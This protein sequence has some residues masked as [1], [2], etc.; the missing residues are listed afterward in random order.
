M[1]RPPLLAFGDLS[2]RQGCSRPSGLARAA[3]PGVS[4]R[5]H[6]LVSIKQ[7]K[8]VFSAFP[9]VINSF[10]EISFARSE[11]NFV[12]GNVFFF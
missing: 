10:G 12:R 6:M 5:F 9:S 7:P 11:Q 1:E 8:R 2:R 4:C 3:V